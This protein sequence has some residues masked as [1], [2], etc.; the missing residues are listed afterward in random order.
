MTKKSF[1]YL[2]LLLG[3]SV[4]FSQSSFADTYEITFTGAGAPPQTYFDYDV[5]SGFTSDIS[6]VWDGIT[7]T[8]PAAGLTGLNNDIWPGCSQTHPGEDTF[9]VLTG[10]SG[11]CDGYFTGLWSGVT[12]GPG[13]DFT[14]DN[15]NFSTPL[16]SECLCA[17]T[18]PDNHIGT[19]YTVTDVPEP[20][21]ISL[22]LSGLLGLVALVG[23]VGRAYRVCS[24]G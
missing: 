12:F 14:F 5:G 9:A 21:T 23:L 2:F 7:W 11:V 22:L 18:A 4:G 19:S 15:Y 10:Q 24:F 3:L 17:Y 8:F 20:P 1:V 16:T 6:V 13:A